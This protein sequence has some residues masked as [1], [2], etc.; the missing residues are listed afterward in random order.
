MGHSAGGGCLAPEAVQ[1]FVSGTLD[2]EAADDVERHVDGCADCRAMVAGMARD[3]S[4]RRSDGFESTM[5][6]TPA[7]APT[8]VELGAQA[9]GSVAGHPPTGAR[10]DRYVVERPLG[11]GGMGTVS[12]AD[13]PELKRKVC[14][15]LLR[16][17]L[18]DPLHTPATRARL[19][20]EAQAMA[21][22]SHPN[23]VA[24]FDIGTHEGQVFIAMEY[25]DGSDLAVW[26]SRGRHRPGAVIDVFRAA[27]RGLAAAHAAGLVH[28]DFKPQNVMIG[29]DGSVK[30]TDFGLARAQPAP[31]EAA[32]SSDEATR[33]GETTGETGTSGKAGTSGEPCS[34]TRPE[35]RGPFDG[36]LGSPL[37]RTGAMLGTPAYMAPEQ[38]AGGPVDARCDQFAFAVALYEG[39]FGVRPFPGSTVAEIHAAAS[40][41][42]MRPIPARTGVPRRVRAAIERGLSADPA[43]R[44]PGMDAMLSELSLRTSRRAALAVAAALVVV[45]GA[46]AALVRSSESD[47]ALCDGGAGL[48]GSVWGE[49]ARR[50]VSEAFAATGIKSAAAT[51]ARLGRKLDDY[52]ATWASAHREACVATRVRGEQTEEMMALRMACLERRRAELA[53]TVEILEHADENLLESASRIPA[54]LTAVEDCADATALAAPVP[55]PRDAAARE[56]I[57]AARSQIAR[58]DTFLRAQRLDQ[59][60]AAIASAL[61]A[62]AAIGWVPLL[63]ETHQTAGWV[64]LHQL[65]LDEAEKEFNA[66]AVAAEQSRH[67]S[68]RVEAYLGLVN[69]SKDRGKPDDA[70][71]WASY[72][73]AA[74]ER[75]GSRPDKLSSLSALLGQVYAYKGDSK[76]AV[77]ELQRTIDLD[78]RAFGAKS[79]E[80]AVAYYHLGDHYSQVRRYEEA[81]REFEKA[82][83]VWTESEAGGADNPTAIHTLRT[84]AD[85]RRSQGQLPEALAMAERAVAASR[86]VFGDDHAFTAPSYNTLGGIQAAMG[87]LDEGVANQERAIAIW[88]KT[89]SNR[90]YIAPLVANVAVTL[91][92]ADRIDQ[93]V[94]RMQEAID[95]ATAAGQDDKTREMIQYRNAFGAILTRARRYDEAIDQLDRALA[96][97]EAM[98]DPAAP[99]LADTLQAMGDAYRRKGELA[100]A[101]PILERALAIRKAGAAGPAELSMTEYPLARALWDAGKDRARALR[102][103]E[104]AAHNYG[105]AGDREGVDIVRKWLAAHPRPR[106]R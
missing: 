13:D 40:A 98:L 7:L 83:A 2:A 18:L 37:T 84:M 10:I 31:R 82:L 42:R 80:V 36:L 59:A 66:A 57:A 1:S 74:I 41:A 11:A 77:A 32:G 91:L 95:M 47:A 101:V 21:Q 46:G 72:A 99:Q 76:N 58:A 63:A 71:R 15:K 53:A 33:E 20:R 50:R 79:Y 94:V 88:R 85:T 103:A 23:V 92:K 34:A 69:V 86:R 19:L 29:T 81:M 73:R 38:I 67:D 5:A 52:A 45:A 96:A 22:I 48:V 26:L 100:R 12:L 65:H 51:S 6:A 93:A 14:L 56:K 28:R 9:P 87:K 90:R 17:E 64:E 43:R 75:S 16:P 70:L 39:L 8:D 102:L 106:P 55:L 25:I 54:N 49:G 78:A 30:V 68:A 60:R 97:G 89:L 104:E 24:V 35:A 105:A 3:V 62:A 4:G 61:E 27:G 44:F